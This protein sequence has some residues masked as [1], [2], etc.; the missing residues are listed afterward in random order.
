VEQFEERAAHARYKKG[1]RDC[2]GAS[3][4]EVSSHTPAIIGMCDLLCI[5]FLWLQ[6]GEAERLARQIVQGCDYIAACQ[7]EA[8]RLGFPEGSI[9][10]EIPNQLLVLPGDIMQS[11]VAL[12]YASRII[13]EIYPQKSD[14]YLARAVKAYEY[15]I[16]TARPYGEKG[17][18]RTNHGAPMEFQVPDEWMTRDL[19]MMMWGGLHLCMNAKVQYKDEVVKLVRQVMKRQVPESESEDGLYGHFYT[20]GGSCFTEKANVHHHVG[21]DTG[22]VFPHYIV[23]FIEMIGLWE[24]HED[25]PLW[26]E[27]VKNFAYGYFLPACSRNPFFLLPMGVFEQ[28][29]LLVFVGPWHGTN[30]SIVYAASMS[31]RF[32]AFFGDKRFRDITVGNLQWIAGLNAGITQESF[33]GCIVWKDTVAPG[34]AVP[35]SQICGIGQRSVGCW[36]GIKGTI[37]NGFNVNH[38]FQF[39][40]TPSRETDGP[41]LYTDEDW[42]PHSGG[43]MSA[44][45]YLRDLKIFA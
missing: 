33:E 5:G 18:S 25:M 21:H 32:E 9:V 31:V 42:I 23:P 44:L 11:V 34:E 13:Y 39:D 17:F 36:T 26:E 40:V 27:T 28:E 45:A 12:A 15:L 19:L 22:A 29:G 8:Q 6:E 37:P 24:E 43:W 30:V 2:G 16:H 4:R 38:Q 7:D 1:W 14:E 41:W 35:Y 10:H 3:V 20:F